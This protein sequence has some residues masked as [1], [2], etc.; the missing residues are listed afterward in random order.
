MPGHK[1][2]AIRMVPPG[3]G[4]RIFPFMPR[5]VRFFCRWSEVIGNKIRL[6]LLLSLLAPASAL[7]GVC[8]IDSDGDIDRD[9]IV[10]IAAARNTP[11]SGPDDPRDANGDGTISILDSRTCTLQC[12]LLQ[13]AVIEPPQD[14]DGDGIANAEDNCPTRFNPDQADSD[15]D[16]EGDAC[17]IVGSITITSPV[18]GQV[19]NT[20][21]VSVTG[22]IAGPLGSGVS[23]NSREA[24]VYKDQFVIN[25]VP[26]NRG[27]HDLVAQ[28]VPSLG[29]GASDQ[30]TINRSDDSLFSVELNTNCAVAPFELLLNLDDI[31]PGIIRFDIDFDSDGNVDA[32]IS[33][34]SN[35]AATEIYA[36]PGVFQISVFSV[37][38]RL[39]TQTQSF[40]I[41]VQDGA[42]INTEIQAC[43]Q[44]ITSG[45]NTKNVQQVLDE[46]TPNAQNTY[47]PVFEALANDLPAIA[48]SFSE[49]Q[50]I[51]INPEYAEYAINRIIDG[52]NRLFLIYFVRDENGNWKLDAM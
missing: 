36:S 37:D 24:C 4:I 28:V 40:T 26:V 46:M 33:D 10:E 41:I 42:A 30:I 51:D 48:S 21:T 38:R 20:S 34:M 49:L 19:V 14:E 25:N 39:D 22:A 52:E 2:T 6:V 5:S 27:N 12:T 23:V 18:E 15:A 47:G 3:R 7:A 31:D 29:I 1:P 8:D 50:I 9:D 44:N 43:W 13:C 16:G 17:E 35:P 11:A 45:F 32:M